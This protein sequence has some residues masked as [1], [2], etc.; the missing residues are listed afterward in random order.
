MR[1]SVDFAKLN[2][3]SLDPNDDV[4]PPT[5]SQKDLVHRLHET[6]RLKDEYYENWKR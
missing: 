6:K 2:F 5:P 4:F 3:S 1:M